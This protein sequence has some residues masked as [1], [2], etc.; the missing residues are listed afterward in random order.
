MRN[1]P[2][3]LKKKLIIYTS[4]FSV[5]MGCLLVFSAYRIALEETEEILNA[6]SG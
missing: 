1:K 6:Q 2:Y 4:L 5:L 3:S